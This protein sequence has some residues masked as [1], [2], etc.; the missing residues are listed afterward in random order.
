MA[1]RLTM[2]TPPPSTMANDDLGGPPKSPSYSPPEATSGYG[3]Q[4][5]ADNYDPYNPAYTDN[6]SARR[7]PPRR[8]RSPRNN[9]SR[10]PRNDRRPRDY[11][12]SY[13][14]ANG[15]SH[16]NGGAHNGP[17]SNGNYNRDGQ[18]RGGN[19]PRHRGGGRH[20]GNGQHH[21]INNSS[22]HVQ[23]QGVATGYAAGHHST[24]P[25]TVPPMPTDLAVSLLSWI[26]VQVWNE[27]GFHPPMRIGTEQAYFAQFYRA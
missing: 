17:S 10:S 3:A 9:S 8:S 16:I 22:S 19:A 27:Q 15:G 5:F 13:N 14:G 2:S 18:H 1:S 25:T 24:A 6:F 4:P 23:S 20:G 11:Q 12:N 21:I 26:P 7:S